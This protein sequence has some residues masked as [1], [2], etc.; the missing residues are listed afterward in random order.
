MGGA[1]R[2]A[3]AVVL[4]VRPEGEPV[5]LPFGPFDPDVAGAAFRYALIG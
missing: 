3:D 5:S 1:P 4:T 2:A